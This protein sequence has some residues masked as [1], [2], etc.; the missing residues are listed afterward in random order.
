ML[1]KKECTWHKRILASWRL[2][3]LGTPDLGVPILTPAS[4]VPRIIMSD[5]ILLAI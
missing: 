4:L 2:R 3:A 5:C 1:V